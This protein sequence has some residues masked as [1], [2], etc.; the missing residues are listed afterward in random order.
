MDKKT[1]LIT[2]A[3]SGIGLACADRLSQRGWTV[4]GASRRGTSGGAWQGVAM[5]V[6]DMDPEAGLGQMLNQLAQLIGL[7]GA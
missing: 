1:I 5:D 2:G 7:A 6:D 3:S 4:I